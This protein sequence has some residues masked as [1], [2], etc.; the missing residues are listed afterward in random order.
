MQYMIRVLNIGSIFD[1]LDLH[2]FCLYYSGFHL[3]SIYVFQFDALDDVRVLFLRAILA[4]SG[5]LYLLIRLFY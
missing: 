2:R 4:T 1:C 5:D 3:Y